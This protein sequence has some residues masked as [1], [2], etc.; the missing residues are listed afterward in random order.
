MSGLTSNLLNHSLHFVPYADQNIHLLKSKKT[1]LHFNPWSY[2]GGIYPPEWL[3][4]LVVNP[5]QNYIK[6]DM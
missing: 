2:L 3:R 4:C 1:A 6:Q 5:L